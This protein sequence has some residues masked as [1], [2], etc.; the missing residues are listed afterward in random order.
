MRECSICKTFL[1]PVN[2][3]MDHI[4]FEAYGVSQVVFICQS[5]LYAIQNQL[6][7]GIS[8]N[9]SEV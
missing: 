6:E 9:Y 7:Y 8:Y 2:E 4:G 5:C 1:V 3:G